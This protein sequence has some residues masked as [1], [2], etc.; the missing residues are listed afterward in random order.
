MTE[1][2]RH[3]DPRFLNTAAQ[4][5]KYTSVRVHL[6]YFD[7]KCTLR[8]C[9]HCLPIPPLAKIYIYISIFFKKKEKRH[10]WLS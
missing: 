7:C 2:H 5:Q 6:R 1:H 3:D 8:T 4:A 9:S 10:D